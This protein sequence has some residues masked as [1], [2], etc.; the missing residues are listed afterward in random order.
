MTKVAVI[1]D[2]SYLMAEKG[3]EHLH[4][5]WL[6]RDC[7]VTNIVTR[8]T[9]IEIANQLNKNK[10]EIKKKRA[11]LARIAIANLM[12]A[13]SARVEYREETLEGME[14]RAD[15]HP[16]GP[17]S[18]VDK[19]LVSKAKAIAEAGVYDAV[20]MASND[21]GI[22]VAIHKLRSDTRLPIFFVQNPRDRD[23]VLE[24]LA[25]HLR[26]GRSVGSWRPECIIE[27]R[28]PATYNNK[29]FFTSD[30]CMLANV[31][32]DDR[33]VHLWRFMDD[34]GTKLDA[35]ATL[36]FPVEDYAPQ[37][38]FC[39]DGWSFVVSAGP[40]AFPRQSFSVVSAY[41]IPTGPHAPVLAPAYFTTSHCI[42][43]SRDCRIIALALDQT[44]SVFYHPEQRCGEP[45]GP[46]EPAG[47]RTSAM[48]F[49]NDGRLLAV[50]GYQLPHAKVD[51]KV[52]RGAGAIRIWDLV[53]Q[54][55]IQILLPQDEWSG[56]KHAVSAIR[57]SPNGEFLAAG[58]VYGE[59]QIWRVSPFQLVAAHKMHGR[60]GSI[61]FGHDASTMAVGADRSVGLLRAPQYAAVA[62]ADNVPFPS[63]ISTPGIVVS[64][65]FDQGGTRLGAVY[66]TDRYGR[67]ESRSGIALWSV[68]EGKNLLTFDHGTIARWLDL[69]CNSEF[70]VTLDH[71]NIVRIWR[72][73][74]KA[75]HVR[76]LAGSNSIFAQH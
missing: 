5:N 62:M 40:L 76:L 3:R 53:T 35:V 8:E 57:F 39:S 6:L 54:E 55:R 26:F 67:A 10:D 45:L 65:A 41:P 66:G 25:N 15:E 68:P 47:L 37:R 50:A 48:A 38:A 49:S 18:S 69:D 36:T 13:Q 29:I 60:I 28:V 12:E 30:P 63:N 4:N 14:P 17:D 72:L 21:H 52:T 51:G 22:R 56:V 27:R 74:G 59:V 75:K 23:D 44:V 32:V 1:Y 24:T 31:Q 19:R 61:A 34:L 64:L 7:A 9:V 16:L 20:L 58:S 46:E 2:A 11:A 71:D 42:A 33:T 43:L 70:A 73:E